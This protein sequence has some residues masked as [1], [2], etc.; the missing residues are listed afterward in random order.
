MY[1]LPDFDKMYEK[2]RKREKVLT[3]TLNR[4]G[5]FR[6]GQF[7]S[8]LRSCRWNLF[9]VCKKKKKIINDM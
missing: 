7:L 9:D 4:I 5:E 2:K 3:T 8:S 6:S 1:I